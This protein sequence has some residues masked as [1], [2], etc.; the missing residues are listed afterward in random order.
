MW[1]MQGVCKNLADFYFQCKF[2]T[3]G[4]GKARVFC[5]KLKWEVSMNKNIEFVGLLGRVL[6]AACFI[7]VTIDLIKM[8]VTAAGQ[9]ET[10]ELVRQILCLALIF[11]AYLL[12]KKIG[13]DCE[14]GG[15]VEAD[16][17]VKSE[18]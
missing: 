5:F 18:K 12:F 4:R 11:I 13:A 6:T 3:R 15:D 10:S 9:I 1:C 7:S 14:C 8:L 16:S 2:K 17:S